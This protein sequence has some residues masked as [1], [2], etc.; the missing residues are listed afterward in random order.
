MLPLVT[1]S[2]YG[3]HPPAA[4][5]AARQRAMLAHRNKAESGGQHQP[6][7]A[8]IDSGQGT[9]WAVS[10]SALRIGL[11]RLISFSSWDYRG[12]VFSDCKNCGGRF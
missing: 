1:R 2:T 9:K 5:L 12:D 3:F 7:A 8:G 11:G 10:P 6:G 4:W